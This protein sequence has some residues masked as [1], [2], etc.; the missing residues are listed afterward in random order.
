MKRILV[1]MFAMMIAVPVFG[2]GENKTPTS[3][4]YVDER[5]ATRQDKIPAA[6]PS[7]TNIGETVMTYTASDGT[8]GERELFTGGAY[9]ATTDSDKLITASELNTAFT[10][11]PTTNTT[12]LEC[13][14][15][16]DGCTLW[17]IVD[18]TAYGS[19]LP[20]G[21][22]QLEYIQSTGTQYINTGIRGPTRWLG[23]AQATADTTKSQVILLGNQGGYTGTFVGSV[24]NQNKWT[25]WRSDDTD[26]PITSAQVFDLTW[27][28]IG[29]SGTIGN[30]AISHN[31]E[32]NGLA[33]TWK[34]CSSNSMYPSA[35]KL[36]YFKAY[37]NDDMVRNF[38]PAKHDN[39]VGMYD[40][41]SGQFFTNAGTGVFI[42]GPAID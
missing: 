2:A 27:T 20:E 4:Y 31:Y 38:V 40:T 37:Q 28:N 6:N 32:T 10:T 34:I 8:I 24:A 7:N 41:V 9:D 19:G 26:Y 1:G 15:E 25:T 23:S 11:L 22:T 3:Q 36:Y 17:T 33:G 35:F 39:V 42:A 13:A 30:T 18:Q 5:I 12:K 29:V 16:S 14:N 21:Y